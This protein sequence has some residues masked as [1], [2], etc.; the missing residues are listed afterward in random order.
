M[1]FSQ[2]PNS[3]LKCSN[4]Q[5]ALQMDAPRGVVRCAVWV[6]LPQLQELLLHREDLQRVTQG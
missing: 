4:I 6:L 5:A 1:T 3:L 2:Q